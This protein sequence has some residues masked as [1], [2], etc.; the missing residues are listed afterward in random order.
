MVAIHL[1]MAALSS[2]MTAFLLVLGITYATGTTDV[3]EIRG[4]FAWLIF[5]S[6]AFNGLLYWIAFPRLY[7]AC[8]ELTPPLRWFE[9]SASWS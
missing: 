1:I 5:S 8:V 2:T 3:D 4:P 7:L 6:L 9:S